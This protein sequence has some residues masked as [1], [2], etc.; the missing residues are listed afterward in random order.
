MNC[1]NYQKDIYTPLT[2]IYL[3]L[4]PII[5]I[6][7]DIRMDSKEFQRYS[8]ELKTVYDDVTNVDFQDLLK[9]LKYSVISNE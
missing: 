5:R 3:E 6:G 9:C 7:P 4:D 1:D 2:K 8:F